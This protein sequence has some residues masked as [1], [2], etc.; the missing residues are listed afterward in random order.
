MFIGR[1]KEL[2]LIH[3]TLKKSS[4][5]ILIYG[6]RKVGKTT[7]ILESLKKNTYPTVYFEC[8][9]APLEDNVQAFIKELVNNNVLASFIPFQT[10][11]DVFQYLNTIKQTF[12]IIIDEY[13]YL[14]TFTKGEIVDSVFQN[15]I[16]N[17]L[18]NIRLF[19]SGS[20]VG[21]MKD[22]LEEKNALYGR[23]SL[24]IQLEEL[25]YKVASLF[26]PSLSSYDKIANYAVFG[27]S[28]YVNGFIDPKES[29]SYNI[30]HTIL[31]EYSPVYSY[32]D[33]ILLTDLS[34][35]S[36]AQRILSS[37]SNEKKKYK[38]IEDQLNMNKN[39]LLSKQLTS[40]LSMGLI[41][42]TYPINRPNDNKKTFYE[43]GDNLMRF[44]YAYVYKNKSALQVIGPQA[45]YDEYIEPTL[46]FYVSKRFESIARSY[47]SLQVKEGR[48]KGVLNIGTYYYDNSTLKMNGEFDVVLQ[49]RDAYDFYE[50]KY[51]K[52]PMSESEIKKEVLQIQDIEHLPVREIGF[53]SA[54]GF[55]SKQKEYVYIT[56]DDLYK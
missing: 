32:A 40:L 45:F 50:V 25:D 16:D 5:S 35:S 27:G 42:K 18:S 23:F 46:K 21:M 39:G 56:G 11:Q 52:T 41:T 33:N 55:K 29:I 4:A 36:G 6:K 22:L 1:E 2:D 12:N 34:N 28:P 43:I 30:I 14:K 10:F 24:V 9:K 44:Y 37:I 15:V 54:T 8:T 38:E 26:Y 47:F 3:N 51:E 49:R 31:N 48:M 13:P 7:L 19:I 53:I 17:N 20:H